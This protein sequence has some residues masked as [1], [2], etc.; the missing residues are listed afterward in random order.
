MW[1]IVPPIPACWEQ[2]YPRLPAPRSKITKSTNA[3]GVPSTVWETCKYFVK[4]SEFNSSPAPWKYKGCVL[5]LAS[6]ISKRYVL[7]ASKLRVGVVAP[8]ITYWYVPGPP[9]TV[10]T[11]VWVGVL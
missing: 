1:L 3:P 11:N 4:S 9:L 10:T 7:P 6:D 5:L 8:S 2:A